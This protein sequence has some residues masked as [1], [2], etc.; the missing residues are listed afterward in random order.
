MD[1]PEEL[2]EVV[3]EACLYKENVPLAISKYVSKE[4]KKK[5]SGKEVNELYRTIL[6]DEKFKERLK[7]Y[8]EI[9][10]VTVL[11]EDQDT[12][13]LMYN[14]IIRDATR[15]GKY[16]V[17]ARVLKEIRQL[18]AIEDKQMEFKMTFAFKPTEA[19]NL[20]MIQDEKKED[21]EK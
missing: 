7:K 20:K 16:E 12:I 11:D 13:M 18:K 4:L 3:A 2:Y 6:Q 21:L 8:Q 1:I 17:V 14:R 5:I 15:D 9:E 10:K 19:I